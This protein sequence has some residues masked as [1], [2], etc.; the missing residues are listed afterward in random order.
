M[1]VGDDLA[2]TLAFIAS[3]LLM[4]SLSSKGVPPY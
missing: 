4:A 3:Q 1:I 2:L